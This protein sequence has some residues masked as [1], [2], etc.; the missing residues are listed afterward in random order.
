MIDELTCFKCGR[1]CDA[2]EEAIWCESIDAYQG[3]CAHCQQS[4]ARV[5]QAMNLT[6]ELQQERAKTRL[7]RT[8]AEDAWTKRPEL[9]PAS[10][11]VRS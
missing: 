1:K 9:H 10:H 7:W 4:D 2:F 8:H 3:Y 5:I 11:A 6:I